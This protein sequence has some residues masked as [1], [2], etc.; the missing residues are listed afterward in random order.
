MTTRQSI[1]A[2]S[3]GL[4]RK[5]KRRD[6][7]Q[8]KFSKKGHEVQYE[9]NNEVLEAIEAIQDGLERQ[10]T[11]KA[12]KLLE[13]LAKKVSHRNKLIK[14]AD[15]S[16][17]GW[18]TVAEYQKDQLAEDS[19]D[20]KRL[21]TSEKMA[22]KVEKEKKSAK[23]KVATRQPPNP[24]RDFT[25][26]PSATFSSKEQHERYDGG[27]FRNAHD[28]STTASGG[29]LPRFRNAPQPSSQSYYSFSPAYSSRR[30]YNNRQCFACGS[31][32]HVRRDC[33]Y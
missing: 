12:K 15:R 6:E 13:E 7:R 4:K 3:E 22:E 27:R 23:E 32:D 31:Y 24:V 29:T 25:R 5:L 2:Q 20:E 19:D 10:H 11:T 8:V 16:K 28:N 17:F 14:I 30:G 21:K 1:F 9:F 33:P 26:R 18:L